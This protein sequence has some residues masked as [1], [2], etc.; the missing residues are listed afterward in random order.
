[1]QLSTISRPQLIIREAGPTDIDTALEIARRPMAAASLF[2]F[3]VGLDNKEVVF[4][5][6]S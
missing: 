2:L 3:E 5:F 6:Q 4:L 1:M